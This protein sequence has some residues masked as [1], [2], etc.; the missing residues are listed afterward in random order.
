MRLLGQGLKTLRRLHRGALC[1]RS[2]DQRVTGVAFQAVVPVRATATNT[3]CVS[4]TFRCVSRPT[5]LSRD[6]TFCH[7]SL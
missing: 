4:L 3:V 5:L 1:L 7:L 6:M 2:G